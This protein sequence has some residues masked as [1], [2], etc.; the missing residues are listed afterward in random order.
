MDAKVLFYTYLL[1]AALALVSAVY[2]PLRREERLQ[3]VVQTY[4]T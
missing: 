2:H 3:A 1:L 4:T